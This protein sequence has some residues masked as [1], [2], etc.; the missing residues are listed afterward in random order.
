[1]TPLIYIV[2]QNLRSLSP[3]NQAILSARNKTRANRVW[4][5]HRSIQIHSC[6]KTSIVIIFKHWNKLHTNYG[7]WTRVYLNI[8]QAEKAW[9]SKPSNNPAY[10]KATQHYYIS[11]VNY[12]TTKAF[13]IHNLTQLINS[14]HIKLTKQPLQSNAKCKWYQILELPKALKTVSQHWDS[15]FW[16]WYCNFCRVKYF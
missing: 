5:T 12:N 13:P 9:N 7:Q 14:M 4:K 2:T 6:S 15:I 1:M 10:H 3:N 11:F 16:I 8:K